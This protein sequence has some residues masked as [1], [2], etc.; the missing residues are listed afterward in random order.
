MPH[1]SCG[2]NENEFTLVENV[3]HI[4]KVNAINLQVGIF[5]VLPGTSNIRF[6]NWER[7]RAMY[8]SVSR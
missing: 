3:L 1:Q 4:V 5:N 7:R 6:Y 2:F 8:Y